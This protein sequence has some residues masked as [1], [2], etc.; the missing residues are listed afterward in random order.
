VLTVE[1]EPT[2]DEADS[3][4][5]AGF[6]I[7]PQSLLRLALPRLRMAKAVTAY[8]RAVCEAVREIS[9]FDRV[10]VYRFH[11]DGHGEVIGEAIGPADT[12]EPF[13]GLHY[14]ESDIPKQAR[15]LYLLN[16]IRL[17]PDALYEQAAI[18]PALN[19]HTGRPLD[20]SHCT[21]RGYSRMYTEYLTNMG[22]RASMSLAIVR[23]GALWGLIACHHQTPRWVP[24][25]VRS[26][27]EFLAD[28]AALQ[29][30]G[31]LFEEDA[32]S[33]ER[34]RGVLDRLVESMA[35]HDSVLAGLTEDAD[36]RSGVTA[37]SLIE[38]GGCAVLSADECRLIGQTPPERQVR[39]LAAWLTETLPPDEEV[40]ATDELAAV[41]PQ[42]GP[43]TG[44]AAGLL[45][46]RLTMAPPLGEWV[47]WFRPEAAR[48]VDW[49]GD[50]HKP[51][52]IGP[53]G[54]RLT[55]RKSFAVWQETVRGRSLPWKTVE[56]EGAG[57]L[58]RAAIAQIVARRAQELTL[59]NAELEQLLQDLRR[60]DAI[61]LQLG[62]AVRC[63]M[64][65]ITI[66]DARQP[67]YP[68]TYSNPAFQRLTGYLE[69]EI[70]GRSCNFLQGTGTDPDA[71]LQIRRAL[72]AGQSCHGTI[73]N[74]RKDGTAFWNELTIAPILDAAGVLTH[75]VGSQHDVT[76]LTETEA[77]LSRSEARLVEAQRIA[78]IGD[79]VI[80]TATRGFSW[81]TEMFRLMEF[82]STQGVPPY[83]AV[84]ARYHPDDRAE[85][86]RLYA[87]GLATGEPY[88]FD[89][90]LRLPSG[91][92]RWCHV[93][94][95]P[96]VGATGQVVGVTGT[97]I[98]ITERLE[99]EQ[100]VRDD[101][102]ILETQKTQLEAANAE[103]AALATTDPLTGLLNHRTFHQRLAEE[104][105]RAGR[106][107]SPLAVVMLDLDNF[108]FFNDAYG[109]ITGD[110][111]LRQV[112]DRLLRVC[113]PYDTAARFGGDEF[114]LLLPGVDAGNEGEIT[115]RLKAGLSEMVSR[116]VG[117][118]AIPINVSLG[119]SFITDTSADHHEAL[120]LA[121]E[122]LYRAKTGGA[123]TEASRVRAQAGRSFSGF[124][125]LDALVTAVDNK[126]RYTRRH[127]EDV[128]DYSL[129]IAREM[130]HDEKTQDTIAVAALLH[131][132]GKIG[133]PDAIL[134]KPGQLTDDEFD[135]I[136]QHPMMGAIMVQAVPGL[137]ETLDAVRHHHERWDGGGYPFG[138]RGEETPWM[139]RLMAVADAFSA[140]TTDR[141]Y[142][143]GMGREKALSILTA[144]AGT[145]WGPECVRLFTQAMAMKSNETG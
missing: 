48:T 116:P 12:R 93:V 106:G 29:L 87:L 139:A 71:R 135:A 115:A 22:S 117:G 55:P 32:D 99:R 129:M 19:P 90:R 8:C 140:M 96:S 9:G 61:L 27:C 124:P 57:Y 38:A 2:E 37:L 108:K 112:A 88:Q 24:H 17:M 80:D 114:A 98:D 89:L 113:R 118:E 72:D 6:Q 58:R 76:A 35:R 133:V 75:F 54:D 16:G 121:D 34:I 83:D 111:V 31:K 97:M 125:M 100:R 123:E 33:R 20:M 138:L 79:W 59:L 82:D 30:V 102:L 45:A 103:L 70:V 104:T 14:P 49:G 92:S 74:Y 77:A 73:L 51:Y 85:R 145:Q 126:D 141:P 105:A 42:A 15:A 62:A 95:V 137:E 60:S 3:V 65:G 119:M 78:G 13:L 81:S 36:D 44:R 52:E 122:R 66:A 4:G 26:S 128:L 132:V 68:M 130:G 53:L 67:G 5:S 134:R 7:D 21:L 86:D 120:R 1:L 110:S 40:W 131:D 142:R 109:H 23:D 18:V 69:R 47:L 39:A 101:N 10:M 56:T 127:S 43:Q 63:T 91:T 50:P 84:M 11:E 144:G 143:R 25:N 64:D 136:K 94:G 41:Y 46:A 28:I 107:G